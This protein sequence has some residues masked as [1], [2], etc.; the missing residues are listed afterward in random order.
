MTTFKART[1]FL[2]FVLGAA[3]V[4]IVARLFVIQIVEGKAYAEQSKK[5]TQQRVLVPAKR[6]NILDRKG[7]VL[8]TSEESRFTMSVS[9]LA[10]GANE[11]IGLAGEAHK[12]EFVSIKR[13]YPY[14][15]MAGAV[16]GY[17]GKDGG[18]LGGIEFYFERSL[19]GENGWTILNR[20]G[21]NNT[22][23]KI[24][25]PSKAP[26]NGDDVYLTIDI[27]IQKIVENTLQQAVT[28]L[29]ACGGMCIIMDPSTGKILAMANEP[30]FNPNIA[31][32]YPVSQRLNKCVNYTY[33]PG[34]TFKTV[35]AACALQENIKKETDTVDGNR[36]IYEVF[37][38]KI[39]DEKPY[40]RLSFSDAFKYSSNVCFAKVA[41]DVGN[42]RLYKY[43]KDFGFGTQS[44]IQLPGEEMGIVHPVEK[45]SGRTRVTMAIGQEISVT[46][47][48]MALLF[49]S[50]ANDGV[51]AEPRIVEKI[52]KT[53]TPVIDS[54]RYK[55]V[56]RV[57]SADVAR[58]LRTMMCGV[59][60]GGTGAKAA[61]NGITIGGKT[62]TSQKV[63]KITGSYSDKKGWASFIGFLPA[64]NPM[65]LGA[66]VIDEPANAEFGGAAAA[67][68]FRKIMTQII[69][70]P[71]LE[72]AEKILHQGALVD[73]GD[74]KKG[75]PIPDVCG[76]P[77]ESA[78]HFLNSEQIPFEL[79]GEK[80]GT[81]AFQTPKV[82]SLLDADKKMILYTCPAAIDAKTHGDVVVPRCIDKDLRDA[83]NALNLKGLAPY[84]Q[85]AG[86]V[87][88]QRPAC[89][90]LVRYADK[91][92]L[93]CSFPD[94]AQNS[95]ELH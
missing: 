37:G 72:Y 8:A 15:E 1:L 14:G 58:R 9:A 61:I 60:N 16:L 11:P 83:I 49:A 53:D 67:P 89:G 10:E 86:T 33:E 43:A 31:D 23:A 24:G 68:V 74:A 50:I 93:S 3:F 5:Q 26:R 35:T 7:H 52:V 46:V 65:L 85:G 20:D 6:G 29:K 90:T 77:A 84:V 80:N 79:V 82:G 69:S 95:T 42:D 56:R 32:R 17:T 78:A 21:K 81:V 44:G 25:L 62:G 88:G 94:I 19:K 28:S 66:I 73:G 2:V 45:W 87:R 55:P 63:D 38:E 47:L 36:G 91:C 75:R 59:V 34:S 71:Q 13:M 12:S 51:L 4:A 30:S 22:Y 57:I 48:Q 70:H 40:G 27:D 92:T 54:A 76:M 18:G 39:H 41:N 64:E